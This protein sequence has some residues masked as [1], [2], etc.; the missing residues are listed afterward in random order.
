MKTKTNNNFDSRLK[1][2][3]GTT[4]FEKAIKD[5]EFKKMTKEEL[6]IKI[7]ELQIKL[8]N[9]EEALFHVKVLMPETY[10]DLKNS[11]FFLIVNNFGRS[12]T[13]KGKL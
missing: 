3:M 8:A 13:Q 5:T 6:Q 2:L 12:L 7:K 4:D 9:Y 10:N 11:S 1:D